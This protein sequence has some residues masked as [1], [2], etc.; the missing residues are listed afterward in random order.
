MQ[1]EKNQRLL[2]SVLIVVIAILAGMVIY[3]FLLKPAI[4]GYAIQAQNQGVNYAV[5]TIAQKASNCQIVPL[6]FGNQTVDVVSVDCVK[7][8]LRQG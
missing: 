1:K 2:I 8:A 3:S 4:S 5:F 6:P 7:E